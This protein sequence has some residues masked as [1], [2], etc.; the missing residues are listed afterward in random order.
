MMQWFSSVRIV[1]ALS[2]G[3]FLMASAAYAQQGVS[4]AEQQVREAITA[5]TTAY[6]TNDLDTYF[7]YYA[8]DMTWWGPRGNRNEMEERTPKQ[9]YMATYPGSVERTG[10]YASHEVSDLRVQVSPDAGAAV[11]S[12]RIDLVRKNPT[13]RRPAD[14]AYE[15]TTVLFKRGNDWKIVHFHYQSIPPPREPGS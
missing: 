2:V 10:G 1:A 8:E 15:M 9:N 13:E 5:F 6:G 7:S 14:I 3:T 11:A 4:G 12:Y